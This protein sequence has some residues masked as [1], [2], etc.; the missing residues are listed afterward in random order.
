MW[1]KFSSMFVFM[2]IFYLES[3]KL[4]W[5]KC[6]SLFF[7][8]FENVACRLLHNEKQ[9][10]KKSG[11]EIR[12]SKMSSRLSFHF[13]VDEGSSNCPENAKPH[14]LLISF[15]NN[16]MRDEHWRETKKYKILA[17][18]PERKVIG[19]EILCVISI[20]ANGENVCWTISLLKWLKMLFFTP[21]FNFTHKWLWCVFFHTWSKEL[22]NETFPISF[23]PSRGKVPPPFDERDF[24]QIDFSVIVKLLN[25]PRRKNQH[26]RSKTRFHWNLEAA[27]EQSCQKWEF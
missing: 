3:S 21:L 14:F 2:F 13:V 15:L 24:D 11:V 26:L 8:F 5:M 19:A 23:S 1:G 10:I 18:K 17:L 16:Q 7:A 6:G 4:K 20:V 22:S 27:R 9:V 25:L 12:A